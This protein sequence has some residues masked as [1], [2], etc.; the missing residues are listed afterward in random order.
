MK[1]PEQVKP[2]TQRADQWLPGA[3]GRGVTA[4]GD[5]LHFRGEEKFE[6]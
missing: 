5:G 3:R 2:Q 6:N 4:N 1:R